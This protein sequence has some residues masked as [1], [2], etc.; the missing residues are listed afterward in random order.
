[1][2][3]RPGPAA[4][5]QQIADGHLQ[6]VPPSREQAERLLDQAEAH[7]RAPERIRYEDPAGA[8]TFMYDATRKSLVANLENLGLRPTRRVLHEMDPFR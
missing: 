1:M 2:A 4:I 5:R 7:L 3:Y 8:D 6:S